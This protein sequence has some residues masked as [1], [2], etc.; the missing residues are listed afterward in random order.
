MIRST[1]HPPF[2]L[3]LGTTA[4][5]SLT[6][7]TVTMEFAAFPSFSV[8]LEKS[9]RTQARLRLLLA[10]LGHPAGARRKPEMNDSSTMHS[11]ITAPTVHSSQGYRYGTVPFQAAQVSQGPWL[12]I[13]S[14]IHPRRPVMSKKLQ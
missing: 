6:V 14:E 13:A 2:R 3:D 8:K 11:E 10:R 5:F 4:V 7:L 12:P 1:T 9:L